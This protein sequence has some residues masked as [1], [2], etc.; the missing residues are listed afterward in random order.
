MLRSTQNPHP[1]N[2]TTWGDTKQPN[3]RRTCLALV[4]IR[5]DTWNTAW[6]PTVDTGAA[7]PGSRQGSLLA[8]EATL[9]STQ[10]WKS[11][12]RGYRCLLQRA[13]LQF[14]RP[15]TMG[16]QGNLSWDSDLSNN[17]V[18]A[19]A[20]KSLR[21]NTDDCQGKLLGASF[22][23]LTLTALGPHCLR[24]G[25]SLHGLENRTDAQNLDI[26]VEQ[27]RFSG[28][29]SAIARFKRRLD[30]N[31]VVNT[32]ESHAASLPT[33]PHDPAQSL[34]YQNAISSE[35]S[36]ASHGEPCSS[37]SNVRRDQHTRKKHGRHF[38]NICFL[39]AMLESVINLY[40]RLGASQ[41]QFL[42]LS[43]T[44]PP[45]ARRL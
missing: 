9:L 17:V 42:F 26:N 40:L 2:G 34:N 5:T 35:V 20:A 30:Q 21:T 32:R 41:P 11:S 18:Q 22:V 36:A 15:E 45:R 27:R 13:I 29:P 10:V 12:S 43:H 33:K 25:R 1:A 3:H 19:S 38:P 24:S 7:D 28:L 44:S 8:A 16:M 37:S 39:A 31:C 14:R 4:G 23:V 6:S